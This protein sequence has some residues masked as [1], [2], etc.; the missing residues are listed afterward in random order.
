MAHW[1]GLG[2]SNYGCVANAETH[3]AGFHMTVYQLRA[4]GKEETDYS[5]RRDPNGWDGPFSNLDWACAGDFAHRGEPALRARHAQ[6]LARLMDD[7]PELAPICE[8]VTQPWADR[9]VYY[10]ARWYGTGNLKEYTGVGHTTWSHVSWYRSRAH[11]PANLWEDPVVTV[12]PASVTAI[13]QA[14]WRQAD[15]QWEIWRMHAL[16]N[17]LDKT[18][19]GPGAGEGNKLKVALGGLAAGIAALAERADDIDPAALAQVQA[20][21]HEGAMAGAVAAVGPVVDGILERLQG[22]T[23]ITVEQVEAAAREA[24]ADLR[25]TVNPAP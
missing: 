9:P 22:Q 3:F 2:G 23:G 10:W 14:V 21:A 13:A 25:L 12:D 1:V 20:V 15:A 8:M 6:L 19:G 7:D 17:N 11:I 5:T 18:A 16:Y 24:L 4:L